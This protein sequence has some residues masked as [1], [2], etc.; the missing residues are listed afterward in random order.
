MF[1][2]MIRNSLLR[3]K[4]KMG[5]I[6]L[7]IM[8]GTSL[9][10]AML[11]IMLDVGDEINKELKTYGAN[12]NVVSKDASLLGD[13]YG[14]EEGEGVSDKFLNEDDITKLKTIF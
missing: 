7:T 14:V 8:L 2:R 12:I 11:S 3:Q 10:V 9:S 4:K 5:L 1:W 6:V 13:I